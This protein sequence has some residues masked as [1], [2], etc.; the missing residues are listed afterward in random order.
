MRWIS[1]QLSCATRY[2]KG[3][4]ETSKHTGTTEMFWVNKNL[5]NFNV[6]WIFY[7]I[8][9]FKT[10]SDFEFNSWKFGIGK[11]QL[12]AKYLVLINDWRDSFIMTHSHQD[13]MLRMN[14]V[15]DP[16]HLIWYF[17]ELSSFII[18]E[19]E[20]QSAWLLIMAVLKLTSRQHSMSQIMEKS[21][22]RLLSF[23]LNGI[24][25]TL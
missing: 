17:W 11:E 18:T 13:C 21:K 3:R 12:V 8:A 19:S 4:C 6:N 9:I 20:R 15:Q 25:N 24:W 22:P 14:S 23:S 16:S 10:I 7:G 2:P 1:C 5:Q